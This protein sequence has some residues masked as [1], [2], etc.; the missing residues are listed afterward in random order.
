MLDSDIQSFLKFCERCGMLGGER[1]AFY[2]CFPS[3]R[4]VET[5]ALYHVL[6][7]KHREDDRDIKLIAGQQF[8]H[9]PLCDD[10]VFYLLS[11][12]SAAAHKKAA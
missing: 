1:L 8:P 10:I 5:S 11:E 2:Y 12:S 3:G 4:V 7:F 9:C 6:H